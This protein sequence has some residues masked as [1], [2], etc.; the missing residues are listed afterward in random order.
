[1]YIHN[2][3]YKQ[4]QAKKFSYQCKGPFEIKQRISPLIYK[5]QLTDGTFAIIH[6]NRLKR[7]YGL[8]GSN[9]VVL[10]KGKAREP[11]KLHRENGDIFES[12]V[13]LTDWEK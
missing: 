3:T 13:D 7:A 10:G 1:M 6:I 8:A 2:S 5:V 12:N 4:G 9:K 11:V